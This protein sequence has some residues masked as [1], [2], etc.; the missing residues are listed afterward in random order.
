MTGISTSRFSFKEPCIRAWELQR[1]LRQR[2]I[3]GEPL[4]QGVDV[5][6]GD[7]GLHITPSLA[8]IR[9]NY[10]VLKAFTKCMAEEGIISSKHVHLIKDAISGFYELMQIDITKAD[11]KALCH[12]VSWVVKKMLGVLKRKW[13]RWEMPRVP[14]LRFNIFVHPSNAVNPYGTSNEKF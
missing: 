9:R 13:A 1:D 7:P 2:G 4:I 6:D 11:A 10:H 12:G 8:N 3:K 14:W 5:G